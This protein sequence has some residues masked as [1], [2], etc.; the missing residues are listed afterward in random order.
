MTKILLSPL[1]GTFVTELVNTH[2]DVQPD[3]MSCDVF[4]NSSILQ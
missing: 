4:P 3:I 1:P 2:L